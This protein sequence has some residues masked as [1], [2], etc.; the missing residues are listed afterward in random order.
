MPPHQR[1][2][3]HLVVLA[4]EAIQQLAIAGCSRNRKAEQGTADSLA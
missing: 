4:G 3:S 1:L 2:E